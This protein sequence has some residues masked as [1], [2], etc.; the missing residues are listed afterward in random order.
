MLAAPFIA[1]SIARADSLE[2]LEEGLRRILE[3]ATEG[4]NIIEEGVPLSP[5]QRELLDKALR[6]IEGPLRIILNPAVAPSL[7][8]VNAGSILYTVR[9]ITLEEYAA[10][11]RQLA[12]EAYA[13]LRFGIGNA[14]YVGSRIRTI[15]HWLPRYRDLAGI[16]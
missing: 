15:N 4:E 3:N 16:G 8:P 1:T 9:P 13:E 7:D 10:S 5:L 11:V 6:K 14:E 12:R 2:T